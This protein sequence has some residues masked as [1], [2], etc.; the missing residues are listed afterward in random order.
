MPMAM[1]TCWLSATARIAMPLRDFKKNQ[2]N[3]ARNARLTT[4]P[5][6][7][8]GGM[9]SGPS[10]NGS[11]RIG[12]GSGLLPEK[13]V[14]GPT[15]RRIDASPIVAMTT[16]ITGRPMSL[17]SMTRSRTKPNT[18]RLAMASA[19]SEYIRPIRSP[20]DIKRQKKPRSSDTGHRRGVDVLDAHTRLHDGL[21]AVLV[22]DGGLQLDR[23]AARVERV[24]DR[25]VLLGHEAPPDFSRPRHL[26]VVGLEVLGEQEEAPD[27]CRLRQGLVALADLLADQVAHLGLQAQIGVARVGNPAPLGP[28]PDRVQIDGDHRADEGA[29]AAEG[30][31]LAD[32]GAELQL[33]LDELRR[34]GRAVAQRA[35]ILGPIDD[36]QV[37]S[38]I[39]EPR[40]ACPEPAVGIDD[41]ARGLLVL[42]VALEDDGA[43]D[44][45]LAAVGD[46]DL[47]ARARPAGGRRIRLGARLQ[48]HQAGG[49][50]GAV[51]LLQVDADRAEEPE[52]VGA[53]RRAARQRPLRAAQAELIADR[54]VDEHVPDQARQ[55]QG[56][57]DGLAVGAEDLGALGGTAEALEDPPLDR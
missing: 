34:E 33:V 57:R 31:R 54:R 46:L 14:K 11:S 1:A 20:F 40:V 6:T 48:R 26:G 50:R 13:I 41:L 28:V 25:R 12:S 49:F 56:Q 42:Q 21:T 3:P 37:S 39:H 36:D 19:M 15:P 23:A 7:W 47:D 27:P 17:R 5:S 51:D 52:R 24:D 30:H 38:R 55:P 18:T 2:P 16:A 44:E 8:M 35:D 4:A 32:E 22:G 53:Q 43:A 45:H 9:K 29:V 10:T